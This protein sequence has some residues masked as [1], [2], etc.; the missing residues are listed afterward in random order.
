MSAST[1]AAGTRAATNMRKLTQ[2]LSQASASLRVAQTQKQFHAAVNTQSNAMGP[3]PKPWGWTSLFEAEC[4]RPVPGQTEEAQ[5]A[6]RRIKAEHRQ[7]MAALAEFLAESLGALQR[8]GQLLSVTP[9]SLGDE[10][11]SSTQLEQRG[12][13]T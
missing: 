12:R 1:A 13:S 8:L 2:V 6:G 4:G 5:V 11:M 10:Q 7:C 3:S 9:Y